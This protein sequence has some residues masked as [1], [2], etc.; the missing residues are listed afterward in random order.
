[1][2]SCPWVVNGSSA[3]SVITPARETRR[4]RVARWAMPSGFQASAPSRDFFRR[5]HREQRQRRNAQFDPFRRLFQQQ[6]DGQALDARHRGHRFATVLTVQHEHRQDQVIDG[7]H[8]F[9]NQATRKIITAVA[10]QAGGG[11]KRLAGVKLTADS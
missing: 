7:Q 8:V 1:M 3:T 5:R 2:P 9:T 4:A 10:T 11:N 6:I